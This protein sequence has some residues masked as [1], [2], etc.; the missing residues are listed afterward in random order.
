MTC[1]GAKGQNLGYLCKVLL[2]ISFTQT[3]LNTES[4]WWGAW[5]RSWRA[6]WPIFH[7]PVILP[8]IL[9]IWQINVVLGILVQFDTKTEF[10]SV[11]PIFHYPVTF[12]CILKKIWWMNVILEK[13]FP[14]CTEI[15]LIVYLGQC[16][17]YS[18]SNNLALYLEDSYG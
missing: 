7:G 8:Y 15:D 4:P 16:D 13:L 2:C 6:W 5:F 3:R 10:K 1:G 11:C 18:W 17:L 14:G 12:L 9:T